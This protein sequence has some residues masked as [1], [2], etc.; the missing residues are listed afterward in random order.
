MQDPYSIL[1]VAHNASDE[2]IKKAYRRLVKKYH[3][4]VNKNPAQKKSLKKFKMPMIPLWTLKNE[5]IA[6]IFGEIHIAITA[7]AIVAV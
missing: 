3:P 1:G 6:V 4:D 2:E 7:M 5:A